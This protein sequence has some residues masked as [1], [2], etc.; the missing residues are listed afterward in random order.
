MTTPPVKPA[1]LPEVN[2]LVAQKLNITKDD[3]QLAVRAVLDSIKE[4]MLTRGRVQ[5]TGF[6]TFWMQVRPAGLYKKYICKKGEDRDIW[7]PDR[8]YGY[9]R[10]SGKLAS[11]IEGFTNEPEELARVKALDMPRYNKAKAKM[12]EQAAKRAIWAAADVAQLEAL[13]AKLLAGEA[14]S[15]PDKAIMQA[16]RD[17]LG[18]GGAAMDPAVKAG[19]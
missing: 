8:V 19:L 16:V 18:I 9:S 5:L 13:K 2:D 14:V 6:A 7:R 15:V 1:K 12:D 11:V 4:L 3:A 17:E 10:L